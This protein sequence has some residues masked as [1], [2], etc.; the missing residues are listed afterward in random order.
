MLVLVFAVLHPGW[1]RASG[2]GLLRVRACDGRRTPAHVRAAGEVT[3]KCRRRTR[4]RDCL[5]LCTTLPSTTPCDPPASALGDEALGTVGNALLVGEGP[6][7]DVRILFGVDYFRG[8]FTPTLQGSP[9]ALWRTMPASAWPSWTGAD[10]L[11]R[12]TTVRLACCGGKTLAVHD[13]CLIACRQR[14][15]SRS[16]WPSAFPLSAARGLAGR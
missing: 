6:E 12:S 7:D 2:K 16:S 4:W 15:D 5:R 13:G 14:A 9:S 11:P 10:A 3:R 1:V 8:Q